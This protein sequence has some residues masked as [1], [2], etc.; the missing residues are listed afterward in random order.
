MMIA[1]LQS[2][3]WTGAACR[4]MQQLSADSNSTTYSRRRKLHHRAQAYLYV[5]ITAQTNVLGPGGID[6]E[7]S[8]I[9]GH[10]VHT[11]Q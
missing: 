4:Y 11:A 9:S 3:V 7:P 2:V 6:S 10:T 1:I 5:L 8:C